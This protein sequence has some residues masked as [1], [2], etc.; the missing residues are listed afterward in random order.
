MLEWNVR[1]QPQSNA[2]ALP[3]VSGL[4]SDEAIQPLRIRTP[5]GE[6]P[7]VIELDNGGNALNCTVK[8][9]AVG[10]CPE[11]DRLL[12]KRAEAPG[13]SSVDSFPAKKRKVF[14]SMIIIGR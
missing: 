13:L 11:V 8:T 4:L 3:F 5:A 14:L 2:P 7:K 1:K 9:A 10:L 12:V 6:R